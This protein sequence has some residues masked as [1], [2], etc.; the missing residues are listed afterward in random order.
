MVTFVSRQC[1]C[2]WCCSLLRGCSHC[3]VK[4]GAWVC[5]YQGWEVAGEL[6][7]FSWWV[8]YSVTVSEIIVSKYSVST[9][10]STIVQRDRNIFLLGGEGGMN[11]SLRDAACP[12]SGTW[13]Q[14]QQGSSEGD[15]VQV[16][17][18]REA[19]WESSRGCSLGG[20]LRFHYFDLSW[21]E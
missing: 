18:D 8:F 14:L 2:C 4:G 15:V 16:L 6:R 5:N 13:G 1:P 10:W 11:F 20:A 19:S 7:P 9:L 12:C 17:S 21:H 3:T